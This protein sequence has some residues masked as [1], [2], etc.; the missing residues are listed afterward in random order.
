MSG[1]CCLGVK[2]LS[3]CYRQAEGT[4]SCRPPFSL[5]EAGWCW[6][7]ARTVLGPTEMPLGRKDGAG[8]CPSPTNMKSGTSLKERL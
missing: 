8:W 5:G 1:P 2:N 7:L 6:A 4:C 3:P